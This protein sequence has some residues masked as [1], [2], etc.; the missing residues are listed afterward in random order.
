MH[1]R[2]VSEANDQPPEWRGAYSGAA[3]A[4]DAAGRPAS[5]LVR[6]RVVGLV[7]N[8]KER[9]LLAHVGCRPEQQP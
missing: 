6:E 9:L 4:A 3:G 2:A 8:S 7:A 5:A 1:G